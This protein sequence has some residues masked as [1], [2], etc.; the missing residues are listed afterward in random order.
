MGRLTKRQVFQAAIASI[1]L[2]LMSAFFSFFFT[3]MAKRYQDILNF[4]HQDFLSIGACLDRGDLGEAKKLLVEY[5]WESDFYGGSSPS[6]PGKSPFYLFI[7]E[8][9][10]N[11]QTSDL[12]SFSDDLLLGRSEAIS[13]VLIDGVAYSIGADATTI[14]KFDADVYD[15]DHPGG[16]PLWNGSFG[17]E[18]SPDPEALEALRK[19]NAPVEGNLKI[20]LSDSAVGGGYAFVEANGIQWQ[21]LAKIDTYRSV[22]I[23]STCAAI[24]AAVA[25]WLLLSLW[26]WKDAV[27][28]G[29]NA[30]SWAAI[31]LLTN[32]L[33]LVAYQVILIHKMDNVSS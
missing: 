26:V 6:I 27:S 13:V 21:T 15:K 31:V 17:A 29:V 24:L 10:D 30:K 18:G 1:V 20:Y 3:T 23:F 19:S 9:G 33:G 12:V 28:H 8:K 32:F 4:T 2:L 25:W 14:L 16:I 11:L 22:S 7:N 5:N